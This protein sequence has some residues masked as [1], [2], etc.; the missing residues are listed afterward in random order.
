[1]G[2]VLSDDDKNDDSDEDILLAE[3]SFIPLKKF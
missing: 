3:K 1:M 2:L